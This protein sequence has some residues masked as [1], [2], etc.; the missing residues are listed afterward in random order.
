MTPTGFLFGPG[1]LLLR[2]F[3]RRGVDTLV[4]VVPERAAILHQDRLWGLVAH[5]ENLRQ[6]ERYGAVLHH[7][8]HHAM[9]PPPYRPRGV[10]HELALRERADRAP[11]AVL[12]YHHGLLL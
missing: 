9:D 1:I 7:Q 10:F 4:A 8:N 6:L 3:E 5:I 2:L 11:C 12:E